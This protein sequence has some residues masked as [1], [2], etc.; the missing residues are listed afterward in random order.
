[1]K[2]IATFFVLL[3]YRIVQFKKYRMFSDFEKKLEDAI[4]DK[5]AET[6]IAMRKIAAEIKKFLPKGRS[7][8]IPLSLKERR[9]IRAGI[10]TKF[11]ADIKKYGIKINDKLEFV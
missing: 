1:M 2:K 6:V 10:E 4:I 9:E 5:Q 7:K 3:Y 8:Y 11:S